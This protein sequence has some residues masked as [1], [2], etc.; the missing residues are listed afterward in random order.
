MY[1]ATYEAASQVTWNDLF[2]NV[3]VA[4]CV[5][6]LIKLRRPKS[7]SLYGRVCF[8]FNGSH[9]TGKHKNGKIAE[10]SFKS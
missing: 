9:V 2:R 1:V 8:V 7:K 3:Y 10:N 5:I 4:L 6:S